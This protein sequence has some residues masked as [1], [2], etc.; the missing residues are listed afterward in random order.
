MKKHYE[1]EFTSELAVLK[2]SE[3]SD[4]G[5][6]E[7]AEKSFNPWDPFVQSLPYVTETIHMH[8]QNVLDQTRG[9]EPESRRSSFLP[10]LNS[11]STRWMLT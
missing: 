2:L 11:A 7:K 9:G 3:K 5:N 6:E 4:V 1:T 8:S 10:F